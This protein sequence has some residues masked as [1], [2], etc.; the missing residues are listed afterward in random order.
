MQWIYMIRNLVI[1]DPC[2]LV[3]K[4][5]CEFVGYVLTN[6]K[7]VKR[8]HEIHVMEILTSFVATSKNKT[9]RDFARSIINSL[10]DETTTKTLSKS[11]GDNTVE[12]YITNLIAC[13]GTGLGRQAI[14][15]LLNETLSSTE[16][17]KDQFCLPNNLTRFA[18]LFLEV[19]TDKEELFKRGTAIDGYHPANWYTAYSM[20]IC[21]GNA[22]GGS[23]ERQARSGQQAGVGI[24]V[25]AR[26]VNLL[27]WTSEYK[28]IEA[29]L[30]LNEQVVMNSYNG[31]AATLYKCGACL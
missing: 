30:P 18:K 24:P 13:D 2:E 9:V 17:V 29:P 21:I 19:T 12:N 20:T 6:Q 31:T 1:N 7:Y 8:L 16:K 10:S 26:F 11:V 28:L 14:A 15:G 5:F 22:L 4:I 3:K 25:F 27:H 23:E